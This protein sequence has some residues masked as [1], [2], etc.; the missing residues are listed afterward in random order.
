MSFDLQIAGTLLNG[1]CTPLNAGNVVLSYRI[2][3][4]RQWKVI[5]EYSSVGKYCHR[6]N[7]GRK[8]VGKACVSNGR[9]VTVQQFRI[10]IY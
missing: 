10:P 3:T 9:L 1:T 6:V 7:Y 4:N 5:E 2:G 8:R